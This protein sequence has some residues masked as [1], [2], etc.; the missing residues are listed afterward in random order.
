MKK[1]KAHGRRSQARSTPRLPPKKSPKAPGKDARL[2]SRK[3]EPEL[4]PNELITK[5]TMDLDP[6]LLQMRSARAIAKSLKQSADKS[7]RLDSTPFHSAMSVLSA[8]ISH[9]ELLR[10]RL[11]AT[12]KELR[13]LYNENDEKTAAGDHTPVPPQEFAR[14]RGAPKGRGAPS[15]ETKPSDN[16]PRS[17]P[18]KVV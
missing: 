3:S 11:E 10:A 7:H 14:R 15:N 4:P 6:R 1:S 16:R 5:S 8:L 12:K 17:R 13:G 18:N 2:V 9:V